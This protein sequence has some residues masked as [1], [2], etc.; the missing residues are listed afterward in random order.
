MKENSS[1]R[2][3]FDLNGWIIRRHVPS[4]AGPHPVMLMLHGWTGDEDAMWIFAS[5]LP[6]NCL[7][8]APRGLY[9]TPLGGYGWH[10]HKPKAWLWVDDFRPA[11]DAILELL[12]PQYVP[13][14]N[15]EDIRLVGFS[16][17]AALA[18]SF[19]LYYPWQIRSLAGLSGFLPDGAQALSRNRPLVD[20]KIF[21][22]HGTQDELVSVGRARD[23]VKLLGEAGAQVTYCEDDVG[24]KL[25]AS[26]FQGLQTF[27]ERN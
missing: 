14:G 20:K 3:N 1:S 25:S 26:C 23:A 12:T 24:H 19:A 7:L 6:K 9:E 16:Q 15:L 22:A 21:I 2:Q 10:E 13:E 27:F 5:H 18:Y 17:G 11:M 8:L 4:G